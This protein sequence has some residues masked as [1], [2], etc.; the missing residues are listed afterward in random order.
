MH[1]KFKVPAVIILFFW[2]IPCCSTVLYSAENNYPID[3]YY[4]ERFTGYESG[5][6]I[7]SDGTLKSWEQNL[8]SKRENHHSQKL[9]GE[10]I[11]TFNRLIKNPGLFTYH[12]KLFGNYALYLAAAKG[13]QVNQ[14]SFN[15]SNLPADM[16]ASV[17]EIISEIKVILKK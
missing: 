7:F 15:G 10:L 14:I 11:R 12:N 6:T 5:L 8:S 9:S 1:Q 13:I 2:I 3:Y 16:S 17:K 4:G